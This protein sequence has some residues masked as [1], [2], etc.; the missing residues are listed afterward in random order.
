MIWFSKESANKPNVLWL[1]QDFDVLRRIAGCQEY[2]TQ[3]NFERLWS[4]LYPVALTLSRDSIKALW[5]SVSPKW[6]EGF[7]TKEEAES[8]L[9]GARGFQESGTFIL[10]FPTTRS[11]P[12]PDAGSLVVTYV[13]NNHTLRHRLLSFD[14]FY[15]WL[16]ASGKGIQFFISS[17]WFI[18]YM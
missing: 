8:S 13:G 16:S 4:W 3:E 17:V 1:F 6:M 10:R 7:I 14:C 12:H 9:Q 2:L 11:W 15:R 18:S 5:C